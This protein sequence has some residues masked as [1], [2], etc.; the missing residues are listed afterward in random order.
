MV[1]YLNQFVPEGQRLQLV[2]WD[3]AKCQKTKTGNVLQRLEEIAASLIKVGIRVLFYSV[4]LSLISL[5]ADTILLAT[6]NSL[7]GSWFFPFGA[8]AVLQYAAAP[9]RWCTACWWRR[10]PGQWQRQPQSGQCICVLK[11][12]W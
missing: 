4:L 2:S 7:L 6:T 3:M 5:S 10:L 1:T 9:A 11:Q 12:R 8:R